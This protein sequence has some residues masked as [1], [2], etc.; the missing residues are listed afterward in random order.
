MD[1]RVCILYQ[2]SSR[3]AL[4]SS[5]EIRPSV[6]MQTETVVR[7]LTITNIEIQ[8]FWFEKICRICLVDKAETELSQ[9]TTWK[10]IGGKRSPNYR[11][12]YIYIRVRLTCYKV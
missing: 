4:F 8:H 3:S 6:F 9:A 7:K 10:A 5:S 2:A 12:V 11:T 1:L